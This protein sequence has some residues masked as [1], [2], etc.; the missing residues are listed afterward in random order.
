[1]MESALLLSSR[2]TMRKDVNDG[3]V[4]PSATGVSW[5]T[6]KAESRVLSALLDVDMTA[7]KVWQWLGLQAGS[8][9]GLL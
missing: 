3:K 1:M 6:G 9:E 5:G 8:R 2:C 4:E 7:K